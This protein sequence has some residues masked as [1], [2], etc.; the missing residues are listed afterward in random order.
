MGHNI[1]HAGDWH[2]PD[3]EGPVPGARERQGSAGRYPAGWAGAQFGC[4]AKLGGEWELDSSSA[5]RLLKKT[6]RLKRNAMGNAIVY[7]ASYV[8]S[9]RARAKFYFKHLVNWG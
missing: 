3:A 9:T 5:I 2:G 8:Y 4:G 1:F 6:Q 7:V